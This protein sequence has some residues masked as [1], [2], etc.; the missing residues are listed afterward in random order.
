MWQF[1][2]GNLVLGEL[3]VCPSAKYDRPPAVLSDRHKKRG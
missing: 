2:E 3:W 1:E